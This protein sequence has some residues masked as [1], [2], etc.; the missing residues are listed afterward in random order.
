MCPRWV[1]D[2]PCAFNNKALA[3]LVWA[4][5]GCRVVFLPERSSNHVFS[6]LAAALGLR[7]ATLTAI[8]AAH[9]LDYEV[10]E[11]DAWAAAGFV[12]Q[13]LAEEGLLAAEAETDLLP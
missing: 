3:N 12:L 8:S 6:H 2:E 11:A 9:H 7:V 4:S 13:L 1:G 10:S 5:R